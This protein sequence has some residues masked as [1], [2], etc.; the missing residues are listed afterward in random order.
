MWNK[1]QSEVPGTTTPSQES[2]S[3]RSANQLPC[4]HPTERPRGPQHGVPGSHLHNKE[5]KSP[6]T[7]TCRSTARWKARFHCEITGS[8]SD[9][10]LN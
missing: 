8:P 5:A 9:A 4:R 1:S 2:R 3:A 7:K 10:A 6:A